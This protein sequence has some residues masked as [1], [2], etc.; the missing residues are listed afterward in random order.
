LIFPEKYHHHYIMSHTPNPRRQRRLDQ[1]YDT[2][3]SYFLT[4]CTQERKRQLD[5]DMIMD[6]VRGFVSDSFG[7]YGVFVDCYVLMPDHV[8]LI[9]TVSSLSETTVGSWVKAFKAMIA[10]REFRWQA[11]F[12]D[13]VL[14]S[15]ESR[16]EKW[17]YIRR[18]PVR[19]GFVERID[20][21]PYAQWYNR[22]DGSIL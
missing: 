16:S 20:E 22:R 19:A 11:G 3:P 7:R 18:N 5:N 1:L 21:W 15:D 6:R 4:I 12:F 9:V 17:E 8:H 2:A 13:H 14:R 10:K